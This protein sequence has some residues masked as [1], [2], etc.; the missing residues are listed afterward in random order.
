MVLIQDIRTPSDAELAALRRNCQ[1]HNISFYRLAKPCTRSELFH[2]WKALGLRSIVAN[3]E[4]TT[5]GISEIKVNAQSRYIPYT[6]QPLRWHTD[7]YYNTGNKTIRAFAMHCVSP[8]AAGG[9]NIYYNPVVLLA[10]LLKKDPRLLSALLDP[11]A[12]TIPENMRDKHASRKTVVVPMLVVEEDAFTLRYTE[13]SQAIRW[14]QNPLLD[15]V[16]G[17]I[18]TILNQQ[19]EYH[20]S[21]TLQANEGVICNN[22]LHC[23]SA[24]QDNPNTPRLIYRARFQQKVNTWTP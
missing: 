11:Q 24:F 15:T 19:S 14:G 8:A 18:H 17:E 10:Q 12:M 20:I 1:Q 5:D 2:L 3:P 13:R 21:H 23:R 16:R 4:S 9:T 7:G 6:N 22:V